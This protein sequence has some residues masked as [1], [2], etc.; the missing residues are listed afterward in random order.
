MFLAL[1]LGVA[2]PVQARLQCVTYA[3]AE[4]G[5]D[6]HGNARTWW[7]QA[8]GHYRRGQEPR[9]GAVLN[10][11]PSAAMPMGHVAVV[12][13]IIDS[14]TIALDHAN[15]SRPGMVEHDALAVDVSEKGDWS[16][17]RVWNAPSG[18]LGLRQNPTFGFIYGE[19][20]SA[21]GPV[22]AQAPDSGADVALA[23][24]DPF[25]SRLGL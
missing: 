13:R 3:R 9:V 6:I 5:I 4:S 22:I 8:E 12:S 19:E 1:A 10:F 18:S 17:V 2:M 16:E 11:R 23:R 20:E 24:A 14:R 21:G 7:D 25:A 15:W